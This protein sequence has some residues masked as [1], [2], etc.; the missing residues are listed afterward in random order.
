MAESRQLPVLNRRAFL[1][2][3]VK[4]A[5]VLGLGGVAAFA[6]TRSQAQDMVWQIDPSICEQCERCATHCVMATS[7][8]KCVHAFDV[9][10]YCALCGGYHSP[11]AK[12][13]DTAAENQLCPT[14]ALIRKY[15]EEPFFEYTVDEALCIGCAKCVKGCSAFGNGSLYLQV[16]HDRCLN[17]NECAIARVC[18]SDAFVRL[19]IEQPYLLRG[20][21]GV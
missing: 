12:V 5:T 19:P 2:R 20:G 1:K 13:Q 17:C 8:V 16:R 3:G 4:A 9:C 14:G 10:G 7:A 15:I 11:D 21:Q 6:G 18:P